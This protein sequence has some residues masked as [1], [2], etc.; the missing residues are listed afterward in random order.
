MSGYSRSNELNHVYLLVR[1]CFSVYLMLI[2]E[3]PIFAFC[4]DVFLQFGDKLGL[5]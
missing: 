2:A 4:G 5:R 3:I 1:T